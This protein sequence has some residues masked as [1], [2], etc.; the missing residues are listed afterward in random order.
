MNNG[1]PNW[2]WSLTVLSLRGFS[3]KPRER[4]LQKCILL[5]NSYQYKEKSLFL[6][7]TVCFFEAA[8]DREEFQKALIISLLTQIQIDIFLFV[9]DSSAATYHSLYTLSIRQMH[10]PKVGKSGISRL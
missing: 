10:R 4:T 2:I 9:T 5:Q 7:I 1:Y 6:P 3:E 8:V